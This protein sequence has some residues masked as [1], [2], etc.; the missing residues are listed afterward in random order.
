MTENALP[1]QTQPVVATAPPAY[2]TAPVPVAPAYPVAPGQN[3]APGQLGQVRST[4]V[5]ILL[6]VVTFGIYAAVW[7][8]KVHSEMKAH[9]GQ[10][11]GGGLALLLQLFVGIAMPYV[12]ASEV[13]N[14]Y[15]RNGQA[16]P[17]SGA[18]GL[19]Y[20]PGIFLLVGP[21]IWFVKTNGA[22]NAY[23]RAQGVS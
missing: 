13:G 16:K 14:L 10:G 18:T 11:L 4:G 21:I 5:C 12:T 17:V 23:W 9:T 2:A 7:T 3:V 19:W 8:Y 22:L 1:P 20:F 15:A 6:S